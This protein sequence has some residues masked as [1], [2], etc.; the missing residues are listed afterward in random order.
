MTPFRIPVFMWTLG[1]WLNRLIEAGFLLERFDEPYPSDE[2]IRA[3]PS[4][5]DAQAVANFLHVRTRKPA[6]TKG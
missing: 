2:A 6:T 4:L 1:S 5:Q 3:R